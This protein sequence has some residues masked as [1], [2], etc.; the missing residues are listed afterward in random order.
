MSLIDFHI[1]TPNMWLH[2]SVHLLEF[3]FYVFWLCLHEGH[4]WA[5]SGD[6]ATYVGGFNNTLQCMCYPLPHHKLV[7]SKGRAFLWCLLDKNSVHPFMHYK[8][9]IRIKYL[10]S[11][12]SWSNNVQGSFATAN[13]YF[14]IYVD[15]SGSDAVQY[16]CEQLDIRLWLSRVKEKQC[17]DRVSAFHLPN[18]LCFVK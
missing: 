6:Q 16:D 17:W 1:K 13:L 5:V 11:R 18:F 2:I 12:S 10:H 15:Y 8:N 14:R 9:N 7:A 3:V 4:A